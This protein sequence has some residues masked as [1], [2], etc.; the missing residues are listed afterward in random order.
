MSQGVCIP[1]ALTGL[2]LHRIHQP[3]LAVRFHFLMRVVDENALGRTRAVL[4]H[5]RH[6]GAIGG[7]QRPAF[8]RLATPDG[9]RNRLLFVD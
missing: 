8:A 2:V 3:A 9:A 5:A 1:S 4:C 7:S 6:R